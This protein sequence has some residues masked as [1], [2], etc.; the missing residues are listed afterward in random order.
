M[1]D[2][3]YNGVKLVSLAPDQPLEQTLVFASFTFSMLPRLSPLMLTDVRRRLTRLFRTVLTRHVCSGSTTDRP[4]M[5]RFKQAWLKLANDVGVAVPTVAYHCWCSVC[6][7][8]SKIAPAD[9]LSL[10][11]RCRIASC[12]SGLRSCPADGHR[13]IARLSAPVCDASSLSRLTSRSDWPQHKLE[14]PLLATLA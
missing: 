6:S 14:C 11:G 9:S 1:R 4:I 3:V 10:C 12:A 5:R 2:V 8:E 13:R 7:D